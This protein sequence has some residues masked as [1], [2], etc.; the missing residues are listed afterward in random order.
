MLDVHAPIH[1][2]R[3]C[4]YWKALK[5]LLSN[6]HCS[7]RFSHLNLL[8]GLGAVDQMK[9]IAVGVVEERQAV[10]LRLVRFTREPH[11]LLL[12]LLQSG[13]KILY[14]DG[15][16]AHT[17]GLHFANG[18]I[19]ERGDDLDQTAI[20][21]LHEVIACVFKNDFEL[22]I[23]NVPVG[24]SLWVGRSDGKVFDSLEHTGAILTG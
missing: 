8:K 24:Q 15:D 11:S 2:K 14:H 22:K 7:D 18:T 19:A 6:V 23:R 21:G 20:P 13:V 17:W 3:N 5:V 9:Q 4:G 1:I 10:S 16:M 12:K